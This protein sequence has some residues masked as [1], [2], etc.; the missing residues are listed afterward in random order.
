MTQNRM[1]RVSLSRRKVLQSAAIG[2]ASLAT[3]AALGCGNRSSTPKPAAEAGKPQ[4]GGTLRRRSVTDAY[5]G[6]FDPHVQAG[7]Q[8]GEM[9]FFYQSL[10]RLNP[11]T[12]AIEGE[13]AQKWEQ[14]SPNEYVFHLQPGVKW[15]NKAPANGR[16]FSA[17]DVVFSLERMRSNDPRFINRSLLDSVDKIQAV[18]KS[19]VRLTTKQPDA[20]TVNNLAAMSAKILAP[21]VAEKAGRFTT[22]DTVVGT[23]AFILQSKDETGAVLVRNP[24]YWKPGLPYMDGIR[25]ATFKDDQAAWAAFLVGQLDTN[26]VLGTR[27]RSFSQIREANTTSI[28]LATSAGWACRRTSKGSRLTIPRVTRGMRL[29]V[30]HEEALTAWA[31]VYL[32]RGRL[33]SVLPAALDSWDFTEDEYRNKFLEF[34][35]PKDAAV[36]EGLAMLAAAGYTKDNPLK[37]V[38]NGLTGSLAFTTSQSQLM[39]AQ[40]NQL[41]QGRSGASSSS[42]QKRLSARHSRRK[43]SNT[44]SLTWFPASR[45][46]WTPGFEPST[47]QWL[48][49]LRLVH[50]PT[51]DQ[52]IDKQR[53]VFD[54]NQRKPM[55]KE[56]LSYHDRPCALHVVG[57]P[58]QP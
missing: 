8:T 38:M 3:L 56:I 7:S 58:L 21:E 36:K 12:I 57:Q 2:S 45:T 6:G 39:Q 48:A 30:D 23:G 37:F 10:V 17:D 13:L 50:D 25:N 40:F 43:T 4:R 31:E 42:W 27:R 47:T 18:D 5:Q 51:L 35:R 32:G 1:P 53:G 15:Q 20:S 26:Y 52:M 9:G 24:D 44:S 55:I 22:D 29:M 46:K 19:T 16:A 33:S 14:P 49:Q 11:K 34:K 41:S 28:G 54:I